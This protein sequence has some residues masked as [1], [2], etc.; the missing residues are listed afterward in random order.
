LLRPL[1]NQRI[2]CESDRARA[3]QRPIGVDAEDA[4]FD[5]HADTFDGHGGS[6]AVGESEDH[7]ELFATPAR[8]DVR[9]A[10]RAT[11]HIGDLDEDLVAGV[12]AELVVDRLEVVNVN[13]HEH[14]VGVGR[15]RARSAGRPMLSRRRGGVGVDRLQDIT[16]VL[17]TGQRISDTQALGDPRR[18]GP[19]PIEAEAQQRQ[20]R[21]TGHDR[22]PLRLLF[23]EPKRG[24]GLLRSEVGDVRALGGRNGDR[25]N[26]HGKYDDNASHAGDQCFG[27]SSG[28]L[29]ALECSKSGMSCTR[30]GRLLNRRR[31]GK[32]L[33]GK[34]FPRSAFSFSGG[35][36]AHALHPP[37]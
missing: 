13:Q 7:Q 9:R 6:V 33:P 28:G 2:G 35:A 21:D 8:D 12:V 24:G 19:A 25:A 37:L 29:E 22:R 17:E 31:P 30:R 14:E 32:S 18:L 5:G 1:G 23:G 11:E 26:A 27:R 3:A 16:P 15:R 20:H 34:H 4:L 10:A 36:K